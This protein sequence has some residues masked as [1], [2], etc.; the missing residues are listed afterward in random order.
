MYEMAL[1]SDAFLRM[2]LHM[3]VRDVVAFHLGMACKPEF[4]REVVLI[5]RVLMLE[6]FNL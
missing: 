2:V 6:N 1:P 3:F 5:L 4:S